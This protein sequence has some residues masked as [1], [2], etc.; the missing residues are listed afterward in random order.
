MQ[1]RPGFRILR[2]LPWRVF[3]SDWQDPTRQHDAQEWATHLFCKAQPPILQGAWQARVQVGAR[4][5]VTETATTFS[6]IILRLP[7]HEGEITLQS[8]LRQWTA[9]AAMHA[10][11]TLPE[12]ICF[13]VARFRAERSELNGPGGGAADGFG[14]DRT[15]VSFNDR[16]LHMPSFASENAVDVLF[17]PY[18]VTSAVAHCGEQLEAGHYRALLFDADCIFSTEDGEGATVC[19]RDCFTQFLQ[20]T[21]LVFARRCR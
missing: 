15:T 8:L 7:G 14:K 19:D 21:Y 18:I 16:V 20:D 2:S 17:T 6:P 13:C 5:E 4:V 12:V 11:Q 9:Q 3:F 10:F 1:Q